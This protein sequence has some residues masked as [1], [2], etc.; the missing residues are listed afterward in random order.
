[1]L[2]S[3]L[4]LLISLP[5]FSLEAD[6][7]SAQKGLEAA[8]AKLK[9]EINST[10]QGKV[11]ILLQKIEGFTG[12]EEQKGQL[13]A[14]LR[15]RFEVLIQQSSN[16]V[17]EPL[18]ALNPENGT[19]V[20]ASL[21]FDRPTITLVSTLVEFQEAKGILAGDFV[22]SDVWVDPPS[23]HY[24]S[25]LAGFGLALLALWV[26]S[27]CRSSSPP[28]YFGDLLQRIGILVQ[29]LVLLLASLWLVY[30]FLLPGEGQVFLG[31]IR[32]IRA[33]LDTAS[34]TQG[35]WTFP[36]AAA[37]GLTLALVGHM[38]PARS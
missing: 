27:W 2:K 3:I 17:F 20:R 28:S 18:L 26:A 19:L 24:W 25:P 33:I 5:L 22:Q 38:L 6:F 37:A 36:Y 21:H 29:F 4:F 11:G 30:L 7:Q 12:T 16:L 14:S 31:S 35:I 15:S 32:F 10:L 13:V 23:S 8:L 34:S 1:M 9:P